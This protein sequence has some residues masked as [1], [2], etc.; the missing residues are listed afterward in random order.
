MNQQL[1]GFKKE[2]EI[3]G[4]AGWKVCPQK[5][6]FLSR[7]VPDSGVNAFP[8]K[9]VKIYTKITPCISTEYSIQKD[10]TMQELWYACGQ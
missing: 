9:E 1:M 5:C 3:N 8:W 10:E 6:E 7:D 4:I 2:S